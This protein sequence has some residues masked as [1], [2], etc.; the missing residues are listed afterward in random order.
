MFLI[1]FLIIAC[2]F[3]A[4]TTGYPWCRIF[5]IFWSL[6]VLRLCSA[7]KCDTM[8]FFSFACARYSGSAVTSVTNLQSSMLYAHWDTLCHSIWWWFSLLLAIMLCWL[9][10]ILTYSTGNPAELSRRSHKVVLLLLCWT[11]HA[12]PGFFIASLFP[13]LCLLSSVTHNTEPLPQ[14]LWSWL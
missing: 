13:G 14:H 1:M 6:L 11:S 3:N 5:N 4:S 8:Y 2:C 10:S 7:P 9:T 12:C